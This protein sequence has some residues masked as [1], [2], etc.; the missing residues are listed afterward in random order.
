[1]NA[2]H[3]PRPAPAAARDYRKATILALPFA[4]AMIAVVVSLI[5]GRGVENGDPQLEK[6]AFPHLGPNARTPAPASESPST[7]RSPALAIDPNKDPAGHTQE[8]RRVTRDAL[9]DLARSLL[10]TD[11]PDEAAEALLKAMYLDPA[12]AEPFH[13]MGDVMMQRK[14]FGE[15][16]EYYEAAIDR[17]P[18]RAEAYFGHAAA[19]EAMG[20]LESA[21]GGMRSYL[22]VTSDKD[23]Y[24]LQVAQAR[25]AIWEMESKLGRGPWGPT[26][27]IPPGFTEAELQR[28][29]R[30]VGVKMPIPGSAGKDGMQKYEIKYGDKIEMFKK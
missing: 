19:S 4:L 28:D 18:L 6:S 14:R 16:R 27:G 20:D 7:A 8:V 2:P 3:A 22:H 17:D 25:S 1:M 23:P 5:P 30:G 26:R 13:L 29:G 9:T 24:R 10:K 15:A 12:N 21:L 11:K